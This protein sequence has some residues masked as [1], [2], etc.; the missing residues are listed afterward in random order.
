MLF[1]SGFDFST[2]V[3]D[4][5]GRVT[6]GSLDLNFTPITGPRVC[7]ETVLRKLMCPPG[8]MD[9]E[10]WGVDLRTYL[11][12]SLRSDDLESIA[13]VV[14]TEIL[15]EEYVADATVTCFQSADERL[16]FD[17]VLTLD[18]EESYTFAFALSSS[19][20]QVIVDVANNA[21]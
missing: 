20:I 4:A 14:R 16:I 17:I 5:S 10:T 19:G 13:A 3:S 12:S 21:G 7:V 18:D 1:R 15:R 9:D 2:F 6:R 8:S 11:N